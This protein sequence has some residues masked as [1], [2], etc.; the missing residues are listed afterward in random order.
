MVN[1]CKIIANKIKNNQLNVS[2]VNQDLIDTQ[3]ILAER[4]LANDLA[5]EERRQNELEKKKY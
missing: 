3:K 2:D 1:T 5:F 4:G